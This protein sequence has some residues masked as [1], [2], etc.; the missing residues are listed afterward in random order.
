MNV[1]FVVADDMR[2]QSTVY[3]KNTATPNMQRLAERGVVF[4]RAF[5]QSTVCNPSRT[6]FMAGR[7]PDV[8]QVWN[9]ERAAYGEVVALP[10]YFRGH[11]YNVVGAGK[12][13]HWGPGPCNSWSQTVAKFWPNNDQFQALMKRDRELLES[14]VSPVDFTPPATKVKNDDGPGAHTNFGFVDEQIANRSCALL[15]I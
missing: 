11:G 9:F 12:L 15:D 14:T 10:T 5:S 13:W 8:N 1:L 7:L 2:S 6:S 3:G 4:D